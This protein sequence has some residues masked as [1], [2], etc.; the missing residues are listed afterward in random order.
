MQRIGAEGS[1][2]SAVE[3][4]LDDPT[5]IEL[6][7]YFQEDSATDSVVDR[8]IKDIGNVINCLLRLSTTMSL[9]Q[10][11]R[12]SP[13]NKTDIYDSVHVTA[14]FPRMRVGLRSRLVRAMGWRHQHFGHG[15]RYSSVSLL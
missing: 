2:T 13:T 9:T 15:E 4:D 8:V 12:N 6:A 3:V 1:D 10:Y 5:I 7:E 11:N 14:T